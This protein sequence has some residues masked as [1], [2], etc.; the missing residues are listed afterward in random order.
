MVSEKF[1][2]FKDEFERK[3]SDDMGKYRIPGT[4]IA[5]IE[6]GKIVYQSNFGTKDLINY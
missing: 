3:I 4:V 2:N 5:L 6:K 1:E